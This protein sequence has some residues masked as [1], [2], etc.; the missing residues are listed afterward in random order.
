MRAHD[1]DM[2]DDEMPC[3]ICGHMTVSMQPYAADVCAD[4]SEMLAVFTFGMDVDDR[5]EVRL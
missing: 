5:G 1:G 3:S 4:C 2:F